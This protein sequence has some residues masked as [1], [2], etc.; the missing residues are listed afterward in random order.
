MIRHIYRIALRLLPKD[1]RRKHGAAMESLFLREVARAREHGRTR[2]TVA[3]IAGLWD[4]VQQSAYEMTRMKHNSIEGS[5]MQLPTSRELLRKHAM[6]FAGAFVL[7]T[8]VL[9][10]PFATRNI[11]ALS[12]NGA[13]FGTMME[14]VLL[15]VPFI[16]AM[17]IPMAVLASVLYE[18]TKLGANG[19]LAAARQ[20]RDG[21]RQLIVPVVVA[22]VG[23]SMLSFVV[24]AE[25]VPRANERLANVMAGRPVEPGE[26]S[27]TL[28]AL[29]EAAHRAS[30][31][32]ASDSTLAHID[33]VSYEVEFQKKLA[34]P[35]ACLAL[36][37]A[38]IA[39]AFRIPRGGAAL[40]FGASIVVFAA[41][42]GLIITGETLADDKLVSPFVGMWSANVFVLLVAALAAMGQRRFASNGN[43]AVAIGS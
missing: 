43:G 41:Y 28:G 37:L 35:A 14:R 23:V 25:I 10:I 36:A 13:S 27:M 40:V 31:N 18:F 2:A 17:S 22:A 12:A 29:R 16:A 38:G 7:L 8:T 15:A 6:S 11:S 42:Y 21:V 34:L 24:T 33:A 9:L 19:T 5:A 4:V 3:A 39:L 26:R 30:A 20:V 32:T 1:L